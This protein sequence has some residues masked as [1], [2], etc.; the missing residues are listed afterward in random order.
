VHIDVA[1]TIREVLDDMHAVSITG[2]G[3]MKLKHMSAF[4][5]D[6]G[7]TLSPPKIVLDI[8]DSVTPNSHL[9]QTIANNYGIDIKDA[10][11]VVAEFNKKLL[12]NLVNYKK[13]YL[14]GVALIKQSEKGKVK[15][16]SDTED[17]YRYYNGLPKVKIS[18]VM[19]STKRITDRPVTPAVPESTKVI[20]KS[21]D[22]KAISKQFTNG[23]LGS[24]SNSVP[25]NLESKKEVATKPFLA[26]AKS[27]E[28]K[29]DLKYNPGPTEP[30]KSSNVKAPSNIEPS[31]I[32]HYEEKKPSVIWPLLLAT[33][34]LLIILL[35]YKACSNYAFSGRQNDGIQA[36]MIV[37]DVD[38]LDGVYATDS[39]SAAA[40]SKL[41]D[42]KD[43]L[44]PAS[45]QCKIITGVFARNNNALRMKDKVR[46]AG[47]E[48]YTESIG[49][50]TRVGL[51][52]DCNEGTD[53]ESF[54]QNIRRE[55][56][57]RAWY[58]D[59]SLYVEYE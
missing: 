34:G 5:S 59:P 39:I 25:S 55:I 35:C 33:V 1:A 24:G 9:I 48:V 14:K 7:T 40:L 15:V 37:E 16:E 36:D 28:P 51:L 29:L 27:A 26:P 18:S 49:E 53:L 58:L 13:V 43:G 3:T 12:T 52:F 50:Y 47:Y 21:V 32:Y 30:V 20:T 2:I 17:I 42:S 45:G 4:F 56:A 22:K 11:S 19:N 41:R 10:E 57:Y 44:I 38:P 54:L 6:N 23:S 8:S 31:P 46:N